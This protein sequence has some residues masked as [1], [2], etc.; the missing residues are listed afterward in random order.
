MIRP[1]ALVVA[2]ASLSTAAC[3]GSSSPAA[4]GDGTDDVISGGHLKAV[5]ACNKTHDKAAQ[6]A[7]STLEMVSS[8]V[9]WRQCLETANASAIR[10]AESIL[11]ANESTYA[12]QVQA[13]FDA[14]RKAGD[15]L[16]AEF[17]NASPNFGGTLSRVE[18]AGCGAERESF[19]AAIVD[20][21][22]AFPSTKATYITED[23]AN[24]ATC[25]AAYD[26]A[27][28]KAVTTADMVAT[29]TTLA[30]CIHTESSALTKPIADIQ[31]EN[32]ASYGPLATAQARIEA[33][34]TDTL[35]SGSSLCHVL[36]EAGENGIGT[37]SRVSAGACSARVSENLFTS[38]KS[39]AT[40][41]QN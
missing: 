4:T 36:S 12:G 24:H 34:I 10:T 9:D 19:L 1:L 31:I 37:L 15:A 26:A 13:A 20:D 3:A 33:V 22:V 25:Y 5:Q 28:E 8:E 11:K 23:R 17:D 35:A 2:F 18:A 7:S 21:M 6:S 14:A 32:D 38:L 40:P 39:T 16:C 27:G 41:E 29:N 30:E